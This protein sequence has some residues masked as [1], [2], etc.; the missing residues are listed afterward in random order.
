MK[1]KQIQIPEELFVRLCLYFLF[2]KTDQEEVTAITAGLEEKMAK[3]Q[4][5]ADY[6]AYIEQLR[7]RQ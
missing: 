7:K 3:I 5:H 6:T 4:A 2:D 1:K